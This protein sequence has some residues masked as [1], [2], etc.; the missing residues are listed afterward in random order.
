MVVV[1]DST[2]TD[3]LF[4]HTG[5]AVVNMLPLFEE[6]LLLSLSGLRR[7]ARVRPL[8]DLMKEFMP[9]SPANPERK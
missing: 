4:F 1:G 9:L 6:G 8:M 5:R 7:P 3:H 2:P